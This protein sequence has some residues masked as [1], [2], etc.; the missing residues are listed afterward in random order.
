MPSFAGIALAVIS[1]D[2]LSDTAA[3]ISVSNISLAMTAL[4]SMNSLVTDPV[5]L[6]I[7]SSSSD[8]L[9]SSQSAFARSG[10]VSMMSAYLTTAS[11]RICSI[12]KSVPP[13]RLPAVRSKPFSTSVFSALTHLVASVS[14]P[15]ATRLRAASVISEARRPA[16]IS[17][18]LAIVNKSRRLLYVLFLPTLLIPL[19][20]ASK[21]PGWI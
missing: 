6:V 18:R 20:G 1:A 16:A 8:F 7:E 14:R 5:F 17:P 12:V 13:T 2:A 3:A 9:T 11:C 19:S 10:K 15:L 21:Y 4:G